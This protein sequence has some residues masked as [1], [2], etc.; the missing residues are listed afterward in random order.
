MPLAKA[1][2]HGALVEIRA[3]DLRFTQPEAEQL[4][5]I[6]LERPV[7]T[8][9]LAALEQGIEGWAAGLR[10]AALYARQHQEMGSL[11]ATLQGDSRYM[12]EYLADEVLATLPEHLPPFLYQT[13][14]LERL[15]GALCSAVVEESIQ[16]ADGQRLLREL[17]AAGVFTVGLDDQG[18]WFKYHPVFRRLLERQLGAR[19]TDAEI[20]E[21][22]RRASRWLLTQGFHEEATRHAIAAGDI[23]TA[24]QW[25]AE[26]RPALMNQEEWRKLERWLRVFPRGVVET[27]PVLLVTQAWIQ[28]SHFDMQGVALT[29]AQAET[30]LRGQAASWLAKTH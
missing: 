5:R 2:A 8:E 12:M 7:E 9:T 30:A 3:S 20:A 24:I 16:P 11:R 25:V 18:E 1:R 21:L 10:L 27:N 6:E 17:E 19:S 14:I 29:V 13:S 26:A 23:A 28:R 4:L 22:H 15:C